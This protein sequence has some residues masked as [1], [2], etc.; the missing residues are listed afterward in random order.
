MSGKKKSLGSWFPTASMIKTNSYKADDKI[1]ICLFYQYVKPLWSDERKR[2][3]ISYLE[4][5]ASKLNIGG[6]MRVGTEGLNCTISGTHKSIHEFTRL[7][8][9][10]DHH[11]K[12][13]D[14]KYMENLPVD[15]AFKDL[16]LLPVKELVYYGIDVEQEFEAGGTHLSVLHV[17]L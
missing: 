14:F 16:K 4:N 8:G 10:F 1:C 6:R 3:A 13:T 9:E 2:D 7:L 17:F 11:F 15:R 5:H 12:T